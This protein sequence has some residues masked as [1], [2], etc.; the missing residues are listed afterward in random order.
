MGAWSVCPLLVTG[1]LE[2]VTAQAPRAVTRT[3]PAVGVHFAVAAMRQAVHEFVVLVQT[4]LTKQATMTTIGAEAAQ[5]MLRQQLAVHTLG[6]VNGFGMHRCVDLV[7]LLVLLLVMNDSPHNREAQQSGQGRAHFVI[8]RTGRG[9][10]KTGDGNGGGSDGAD[11]LAVNTK[12][13]GASF[14]GVA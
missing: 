2:T 3:P 10:G 8:A 7:T 6:L 5:T 11:K 9:G 4:A 1:Q 13:H 12:G 14:P